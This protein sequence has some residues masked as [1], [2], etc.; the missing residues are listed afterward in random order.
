LHSANDNRSPIKFELSDLN[1]ST[2]TRPEQSKQNIK[3]D[4]KKSKAIN[5][6]GVFSFRLGVSYSVNAGVNF[7]DCETGKYG[8]SNGYENKRELCREGSGPWISSE[9]LQNES[10]SM[11]D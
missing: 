8:C 6:F 3:S 4:R 5:N 9:R 11:T 7:I 10:Y 2:T 1:V